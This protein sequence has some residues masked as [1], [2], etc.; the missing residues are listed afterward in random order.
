MRTGHW[1]PG[2]QLH[3]DRRCRA[4]F[5]DVARG[6][7][8]SPYTRLGAIAGLAHLLAGPPVLSRSEPADYPDVDRSPLGE[9]ST[10][11]TCDT[12]ATRPTP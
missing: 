10:A 8:G 5:I 4:R 2:P 11:R 6:H 3:S 1:L 9:A 7:D 12:I